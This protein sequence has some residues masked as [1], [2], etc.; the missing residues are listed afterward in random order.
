MANIPSVPYFESKL[1]LCKGFL[2]Q[3]EQEL[4]LLETKLKSGELEQRI[5]DDCT[6]AIVRDIDH[7]ME[8]IRTLTRMEKHSAAA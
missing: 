2:Q 1:R 4:Y 7:I 8:Q 6:A 3:Y 5:Y